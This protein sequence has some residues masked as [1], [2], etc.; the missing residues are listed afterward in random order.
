MQ[1]GHGSGEEASGVSDLIGAREPR[2]CV[3]PD[4]DEHPK[5][6]QVLELLERLGIQLDPW[7]IDILY[8]SLLRRGKYWAAFAV[9]VCC[10]RQNG[11][12]EILQA[13]QIVGALI[14]K[15]RLQIHSAHLADT[16]MEAFMRWDDLIDANDWLLDDIAYVR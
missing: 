1:P 6:K 3:V 14:L 5:W 2:I 7:Q 13:R 16:C 11:K 8:A 15:E 9:A 4:G 10:P 12:N